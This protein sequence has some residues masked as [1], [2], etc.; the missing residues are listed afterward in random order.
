MALAHAK[1][2]MALPLEPWDKN[3]PK[4]LSTKTSVMAS[5]LTATTRVNDGALRRKNS[6][7]VGQ[8]LDEINRRDPVAEELFG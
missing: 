7:R 1:E 4:V 6:D 2:V 5:I 3:F 8:L